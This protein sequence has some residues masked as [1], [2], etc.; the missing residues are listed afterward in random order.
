M[1]YQLFLRVFSNKAFR[2]ETT[3][4]QNPS[5][6]YFWGSFKY[7]NHHLELDFKNVME[8]QSASLIGSESGVLSFKL[9]RVAGIHVFI[10]K[11]S[12]SNSR[13]CELQC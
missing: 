2:Q 13:M 1:F 9:K 6:P 12:L 3:K 8:R 10:T 5:T 11:G 7:L 4:Q